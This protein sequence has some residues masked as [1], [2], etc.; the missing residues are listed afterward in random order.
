M[1]KKVSVKHRKRRHDQATAYAKDEHPARH[2][3]AD[4]RSRKALAKNAN[5][6]H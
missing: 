3:V 1:G 2:K 4:S 5:R 6:A